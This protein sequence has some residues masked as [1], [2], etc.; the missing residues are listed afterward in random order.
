MTRCRCGRPVG[1]GRRR[2]CSPTCATA[3]RTAAGGYWRTRTTPG[4]RPDWRDQPGADQVIAAVRARAATGEPCY[5]HQ[6]PACPGPINLAIT[7]G[8]W[9]FTV[10]HL[11]RIMDGGPLVPHPALAAPAHR[12]CNARDGLSAQ[13]RRRSG[14][15]AVVTRGD[16]GAMAQ[17]DMGVP[18]V[19]TTSEE[20]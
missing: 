10:H 20:W 3:A 18:P 19:G 7:R 11:N 12:A 15:P 4:T 8:R 5:F 13:N 6:H 16:G 2:Y 14:S 17:R 9:A 1:K